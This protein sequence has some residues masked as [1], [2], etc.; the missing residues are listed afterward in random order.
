[1]AETGSPAA[2]ITLI[3]DDSATVLESIRATLG[4]VG[5]TAVDTSKNI[6][7]AR[8][9]MTSKN[10]GLVLCD[11]NLG[12]GQESGQQFLESLRSKGDLPLSTIF[13]MVTAENSYERVVA[14]AEIAPDDY[15][16]KP[17]TPQHLLDR[18][19]KAY[20]KKNFLKPLFDAIDSGDSVKALAICE[21]LTN[22]KSMYDVDVLRFKAELLVS[23]GEDAL[24]Q[25]AY[26]E[27]LRRKVTPWAKMGLA[28][29]LAKNENFAASNEMLQ[30]IVA[31]NNVF[32]A[33]HD[34][35]VNNANA[36]GDEEAALQYSK[37]ALEVSPGSVKRLKSTADLAF[38]TGD[39]ETATQLLE[40]AVNADSLS[41]SL[42]LMARVRLIDV[43]CQSKQYTK[44]TE[45]LQIFFKQ[46]KERNWPAKC[47]SLLMME[48]AGRVQVLHQDLQQATVWFREPERNLDDALLILRLA[49]RGQAPEFILRP[50]IIFVSERYGYSTREIKDI[51]KTVGA[52]LA[53]DA[54][55]AYRRGLQLN[56]TLMTE[57]TTG[58]IDDALAQGLE[59]ADRTLNERTIL[60][61]AS[62]CIK[63]SNF[64]TQQLEQIKDLLNRY[65]N[66]QA[67]APRKLELQKQMGI[68]G[69]WSCI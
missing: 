50:L 54:E 9:R 67:N 41:S 47:A 17:F 22:A 38:K 68:K 29:L 44:A 4:V 34:L 30:E 16:L 65:V 66:T 36:M 62:I 5:I 20:R 69:E 24:A 11:Y 32:L 10:Y 61:T 39:I 55:S 45:Q 26:E 2:L 13:I 19:F 49:I 35:L 52:E 63:S 58:C 57:A 48:A 56:R 7:D 8:R 15:L 43:Y 21:T 1:M 33:A 31:E 3:I 6:L 23:Q 14:T 51:E 28:R 64:T 25:A 40:R 42:D 59:A 27:V 12:R 46:N 18:I 37:Q 53:N 60:T